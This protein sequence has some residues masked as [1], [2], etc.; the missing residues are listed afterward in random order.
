L[1]V[2]KNKQEQTRKSRAIIA[3]NSRVLSMA[4]QDKQLASGQNAVF[5]FTNPPF[6]YSKTFLL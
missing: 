5:E 4:A 2:S 6:A 3:S 1:L